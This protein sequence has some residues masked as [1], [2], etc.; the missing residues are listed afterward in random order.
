MDVR[1]PRRVHTVGSLVFREGKIHSIKRKSGLFTIVPVAGVI[2][3]ALDHLIAGRDR[4]KRSSREG[5]VSTFCQK[6]NGQEQII[7]PDRP[8]LI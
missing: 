2:L 5:G 3:C 4:S 8:V 1:P 6:I 7:T